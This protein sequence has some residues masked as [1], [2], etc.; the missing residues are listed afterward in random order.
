[1]SWSQKGVHKPQG[2]KRP[3]HKYPGHKR[4][5]ILSLLTK[6]WA[7]VTT[8]FLPTRVP[9][10]IRPQHSLYPKKYC[11]PPPPQVAHEDIL[12]KK[13]GGRGAMNINPTGA[14]AVII[15]QKYHDSSSYFLRN[16]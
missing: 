11:R 7:A 6:Q 10:H 4:P 16:K 3:G 12:Y 5:S 2:H 1:M 13:A 9:P 8:H 14:S 15:K